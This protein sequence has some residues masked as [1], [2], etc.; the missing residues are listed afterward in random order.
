MAHSTQG[1]QQQ[2]QWVLCGRRC[3]PHR[4]CTGLSTLPRCADLLASPKAGFLKADV[5]PLIRNSFNFEQQG[6]IADTKYNKE[7]RLAYLRAD[8]DEV[9]DIIQAAYSES[10]GVNITAGLSEAQSRLRL[11]QKD[12]VVGTLKAGDVNYYNFDDGQSITTLHTRAEREDKVSVSSHSLGQTLFEPADSD[13][14][15][16]LDADDDVLEVQAAGD[17]GA[18]AATSQTNRVQLDLSAMEL[19][20]GSKTALATPAIEVTRDDEETQETSASCLWKTCSGSLTEMQQLLDILLLEMEMKQSASGEPVSPL[21]P[22]ALCDLVALESGND[23]DQMEALLTS[24]RQS[25]MEAFQEQEVDL[26]PSTG[27]GMMDYDVTGDDDSA[28]VEYIPPNVSEE[29]L[30]R[31]ESRTSLAA[32]ALAASLVAH[33]TTST[34]EKPRGCVDDVNTSRPGVGQC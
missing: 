15:S 12:A 6:L 34:L 14:E 17:L 10:S 21:V 20:N 32:A 26:S 5:D 23:A 27:T 16:A 3:D 7:T 18:A 25:V 13:D 4:L 22:Q 8:R 28:V 33:A 30:R 2:I 19:D 1:R 24:L 9:L 11:A 31:T 29:E